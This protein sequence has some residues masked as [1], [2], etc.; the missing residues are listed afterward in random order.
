VTRD[1][2]RN[3]L[4]PRRTMGEAVSLQEA[5]CG[6]RAHREE[7]AA[8]FCHEYSARLVVW[9]EVINTLVSSWQRF[10]KRGRER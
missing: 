6:S 5:I 8:A 1:E 10:R 9:P 7:K 4:R 2:L 3:Y